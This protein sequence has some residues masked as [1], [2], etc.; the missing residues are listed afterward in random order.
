MRAA[1][2]G[3]VGSGS[4]ERA[5]GATYRAGRGIECVRVSKRGWRGGRGRFYTTAGAR[6]GLPPR[7]GAPFAT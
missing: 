6:A 4:P 2:A 5:L 1:H 3:P 7:A